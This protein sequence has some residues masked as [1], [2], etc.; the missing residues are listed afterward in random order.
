MR[1]FFLGFLVAILLCVSAV[2]F[3]HK[4]VEVEG[5]AFCGMITEGLSGKYRPGLI[6]QVKVAYKFLAWPMKTV[7]IYL[8]DEKEPRMVIGDEYGPPFEEKDFR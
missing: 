5:D 1:N 2:E 3:V 6:Y 8:T 4:S 7:Y